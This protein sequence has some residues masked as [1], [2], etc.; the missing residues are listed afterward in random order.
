MIG[1]NGI[2]DSVRN[3]RMVGVGLN[4]NGRGVAMGVMLHEFPQGLLFQ[5]LEGG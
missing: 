4:I 2:G 3:G 1:A 5:E